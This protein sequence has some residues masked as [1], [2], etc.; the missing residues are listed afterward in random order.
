MAKKVSK[1]SRNETPAQIKSNIEANLL[2]EGAEQYGTQI[3]GGYTSL[4]MAALVRQYGMDSYL[5]VILNDTGIE[6]GGSG[7]SSSTEVMKSNAFF[8]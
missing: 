2:E 4:S 6:E 1:K 8:Y 7:S 3:T 5:N